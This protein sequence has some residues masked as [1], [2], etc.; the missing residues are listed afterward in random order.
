MKKNLT[1]LVLILILLI[2]VAFASGRFK[3]EEPNFQGA[4]CRP[5]TTS[6]SS[7]SDGEV[8]TIIFD[9]LRAEVPQITGDNNNN[10]LS[11]DNPNPQSNRLTTL[12]RKV[13]N[14]SI[15]IMVPVGQQISALEVSVDFRGYTM[16][17]RGTSAQIKSFLESV[18]TRNRRSNTGNSA[19]FFLKKWSGITNEDWMIN[20]K[21]VMPISGECSSNG[22][23][24]TLLKIKN[25]VHA[26]NF[27]RILGSQSSAMISLDS[28]DMTGTMVF[29]MHTSI[30]RGRG[31]STQPEAF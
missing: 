4:G 17:E 16:T 8:M 11:A 2:N 19:P 9:G 30:C 26:E 18:E 22:N 27:N 20:K 6:V 7:T 5:G 28:Q 21:T 31:R 12:D 14:I 25:V 15:P 13:C 29:K 24:R 10:E 23:S 1:F 3:F